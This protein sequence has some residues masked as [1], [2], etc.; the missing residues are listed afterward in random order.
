[1]TELG[2]SYIAKLQIGLELVLGVLVHTS[3]YLCFM[4][5]SS[6]SSI[7]LQVKWL[8]S[9]KASQLCIKPSNL[10]HQIRLQTTSCRAV[11]LRSVTLMV[12]NWTTV[13][14]VWCCCKKTFAF[15]F[16]FITLW[17]WVCMCVLYKT[18]FVNS[19]HVLCGL[20]SSLM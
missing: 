13:R 3:S 11:C 1:M 4:K 7:K 15:W 10:W 20:V 19:V 18:I 9:V 5:N 12:T 2:K 16:S 6:K 17:L 8:H 14:A